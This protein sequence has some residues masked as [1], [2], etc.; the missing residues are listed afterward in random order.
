MQLCPEHSISLSLVI[1][2]NNSDIVVVYRMGEKDRIES[3]I[4]CRFLTYYREGCGT[5][6]SYWQ[7]LVWAYV[8]GVVND[9]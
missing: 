1:D 9:A 2:N 5:N 3:Q 7:R 8:G 6:K 4:L